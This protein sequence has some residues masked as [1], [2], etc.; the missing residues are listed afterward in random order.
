MM[1]VASSS[2]TQCEHEGRGSLDL[3]MDSRGR[4]EPELGPTHGRRRGETDGSAGVGS[5]GVAGGIG[6]GAWRR[7][8]RR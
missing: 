8:V 4:L 5:G 3:P 1:A 2:S 7:S 6:V